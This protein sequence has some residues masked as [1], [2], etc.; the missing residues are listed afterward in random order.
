MPLIPSLIFLLGK[1]QPS[2][3]AAALLPEFTVARCQVSVD[4]AHQRRQF[5]MV[6]Q[7]PDDPWHI[8]FR[9]FENLGGRGWQCVMRHG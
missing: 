8:G 1:T 4:T 7:R 3:R 6:D 9:N 5:A 2:Q